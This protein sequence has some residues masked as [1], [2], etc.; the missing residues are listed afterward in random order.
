MTKK[1]SLW[2][3]SSLQQDIQWDNQTLPGITD[4]EL[5]SK[6]WTQITA[7]KDMVIKRSQNKRWKDKHDNTL[8]ELAK[9]KNWRKNQANGSR[10]RSATAE[11]KNN[12]A[13]GMKNRNTNEEWHRNKAKA[14][15]KTIQTPY[16][17]FESRKAAAE[18]M[19]AIGINNASR[20]LDTLLKKDPQNYFYISK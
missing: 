8:R 1:K 17:I 18:H 20:K 15:Q 11:W 4:E 12:H 13:Q 10:E 14:K 9:T 3:N 19:L 5:H 16:G 6:N 7:I 2:D